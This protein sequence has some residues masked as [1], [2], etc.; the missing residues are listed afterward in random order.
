ML[1]RSPGGQGHTAMARRFAAF[2]IGATFR[3][4]PRSSIGAPVIPSGLA[5]LRDGFLFRDQVVQGWSYQPRGVGDFNDNN[6]FR[7]TVA[8]GGLAA[9][10]EEE[11]M[12][13]H[14]NFDATASG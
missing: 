13:F 4:P 6:R 1:A 3:R 2:G 14:A 7:A 9:L 10:G 5:S 8:L 12:Y 11:A